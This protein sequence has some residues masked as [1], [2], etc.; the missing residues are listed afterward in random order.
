MSDI[1]ESMKALGLSKE[2]LK[3][4]FETVMGMTGPYTLFAE[5]EDGT[6]AYVS[7]RVESHSVPDPKKPDGAPVPTLGLM[8]RIRIYP[9]AA[10][11][12]N[13]FP[14]LTGA[15][16]LGEP[17]PVVPGCVT[18]NETGYFKVKQYIPVEVTDHGPAKFVKKV[19]EEVT[20]ELIEKLKL[21]IKAEGGRGKCVLKDGDFKEVVEFY[22]SQI[23][24]GGRAKVWQG[25]NLGKAKKAA[26]SD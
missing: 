12:N 18:G 16:P 25:V 11:D 20:A 7:T 23:P 13:P 6:K 9:G 4:K 19:Q 8:L 1:S 2:A 14:G 22:V 15:F 3:N 17:T 21:S 24:M 5:K 10:G 26:P